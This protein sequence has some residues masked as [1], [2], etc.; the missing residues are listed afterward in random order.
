MQDIINIR[1]PGTMIGI[2]SSYS[3]DKLVE[4]FEPKKILIIT[5]EGIVK[6]GLINNVKSSLEQA[7]YNFD[8]FDGCIPNAPSRA[9]EKC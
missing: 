2:G 5:D 7:G 6:A 9:V 1:I 4:E 3:I 8:V